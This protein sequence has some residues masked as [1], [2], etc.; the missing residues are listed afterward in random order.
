MTRHFSDE[1]G[2]RAIRRFAIEVEAHPLNAWLSDLRGRV[3]GAEEAHE[4]F[5]ALFER[6][7]FAEELLGQVRSVGLDADRQLA[8]AKRTAGTSS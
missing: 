5:H 4:Q 7:W 8:R 2:A 1:D 3:V 6:A